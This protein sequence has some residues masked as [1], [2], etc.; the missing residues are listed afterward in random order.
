MVAWPQ[1]AT[2]LQLPYTIEV[3]AGKQ[4]LIIAPTR[5]VDV[6]SNNETKLLDVVAR[7]LVLSKAKGILHGMIATVLCLILHYSC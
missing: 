4:E 6:E 5:L 1:G 7:L 3:I 2:N